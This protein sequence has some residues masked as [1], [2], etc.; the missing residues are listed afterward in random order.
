M[1]IALSNPQMQ[2]ISKPNLE[3]LRTATIAAD[4]K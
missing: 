2:S 1:L 4:N 3:T